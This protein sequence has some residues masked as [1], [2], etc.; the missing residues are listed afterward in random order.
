MTYYNLEHPSKKMG[1]QQRGLVKRGDELTQP[2]TVDGIYNQ[3]L[4][5][6]CGDNDLVSLSLY[7]AYNKAIDAIGV[8]TSNVHHIHE[9]MIVY[10]SASGA[11]AAAPTSGVHTDPC[12]AGE[13]IES[14]G[15]VFELTGWGRLRRTSPV[16]DVTDVIEKFCEK[17]PIYDIAGE[18]I[19]SDYEWDVV[20]LMSVI[21]HDFQRLFITGNNAVAG[22]ADGLQQLVTFGY[23]N[24][25][26]AQACSS[27]D[28]TVVDW[29][30]NAICP[31]GGANAVTVNGVAIANGYSMF[32]LVKSFLRRTSQRINMSSL[33][34]A[35]LHV[36]LATTETIN[37]MINCYICDIVCSGDVERMDSPEARAEI[38]RLRQEFGSSN[39]VVL[40]FEGYPVIFYSYDWA[41][42]D[43]AA[44]NSDIYILTPTVGNTPLLRT[45]VKE[46]SRA[47][48]A[49][50][51]SG[52]KFMV[53]DRSRVLSWESWDHTCYT[54]STEMQWR[55]YCSA[56]WAQMRIM[57]VSN[58][59]PLGEI[60]DDPLSAVFIENNLQ[61]HPA[62]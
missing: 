41:L 10:V 43:S 35:P 33:V 13:S 22:E 24:P 42:Y 16:R 5:D 62:V 31:V 1:V 20:R 27:M 46:M 40:S 19:S 56:P 2:A 11:A 54:V 17:Q 29:N 8:V 32:D 9:D 49:T 50:D 53:T 25:D 58:N 34:G 57:N 26:T 6:L 21:I 39:A 12:A 47:L 60:S 14:G 45:Q 55:V 59:S 18:Q 48:D 52:T 44:D 51:Q 30:D 37:A 15:C 38:A 4:F 61:A 36:G 23:V 3:L 7:G 28:S